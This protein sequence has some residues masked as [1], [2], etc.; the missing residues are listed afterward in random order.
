MPTTNAVSYL[1]VSGQGQIDGDGFPRQ[2][3]AIARFARM[4]RLNV[5]E[6]FRDEGVSGTRELQNRPGLAE[7][8]DRAE[9]DG[10]RVVIVERAD[11]LAR[12]LMVSEVILDQFRKAD[13]RVLTADGQDL[14]A[15]DDPTRKLIRQVLAA[16]AE[17]DK[18]VTVLKLRAARQ[19]IRARN[20]R[21]EGRKPFGARPG[22]AE[23]IRLMRTL[24]RKTPKQTRRSFADIADE[25]NRRQV[26]TRTGTSWQ[27]RTIY[28]ILSRMGKPLASSGES[29]SA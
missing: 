18:S 11:R 27:A 23:V 22:E 29:P 3:E 24:R 14:T 26:P 2:R 5:L 28:G 16:V 25:L 8:L 17:F 7:I 4:S 19:R 13:V 15:D 12:D 9:G 1:R 6:E 10:I 21:C 20:G